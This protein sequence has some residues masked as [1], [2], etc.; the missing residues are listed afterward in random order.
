MRRAQQPGRQIGPAARYPIPSPSS[1][2]PLPKITVVWEP[3][4]IAG[5]VRANTLSAARYKATV[6][7][8]AYP[9]FGQNPVPPLEPGPTPIPPDLIAAC[10][11][12]LRQ[13]PQIVSA[14][15]DSATT[16]K[17][18]SDILPRSLGPPYLV[19]YEPHED[20]EYETI[21]AR[22]P[23]TIAEGVFHVDLVGTG[24]FAVRQLAEQVA[25]AL[26][27][28]PLTFLDGVLVY[29]RRS[30]RHYPTFRTAGPSANVVEFKRILEFEY[31]IE[32]WAPIF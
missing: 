16:P 31:K 20:E 28:A 9:T 7:K 10:I 1:S 32:R 8:S 26:N 6:S 4:V 13:Q 14:F 5:P 25:A 30:V 3:A 15:G 19:F 11:A 29:L 12:W 22:G 23:S 24:K 2:T 21:D 18:V 17:F 27:D